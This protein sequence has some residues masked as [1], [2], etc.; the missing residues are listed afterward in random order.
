[1]VGGKN[2]LV[3]FFPIAE[4]GELENGTENTGLGI[5]AMAPAAAGL[6]PRPS[7]PVVRNPG[8]SR[9]LEM[10]SQSKA[11][12]LNAIIVNKIG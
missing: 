8:W 6:K 12:G 9:N 7:K 10:Q 4:N 5:T 1:M 2:S 11:N 3:F